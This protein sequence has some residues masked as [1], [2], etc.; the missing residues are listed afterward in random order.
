MGYRIEALGVDR[1]KRKR[2]EFES[3]SR[4][5]KDEISKFVLQD[6]VQ[7]GIERYNTQRGIGN[8]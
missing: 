7:S 3:A 6:S 5:N 1:Y 2:P 4:K 8:T